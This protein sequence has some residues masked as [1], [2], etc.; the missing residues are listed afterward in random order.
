M[1]P[2]E[3]S[4]RPTKHAKREPGPHRALIRSQ[5][6]CLRCIGA[7]HV[8]PDAQLAR[9]AL[10]RCIEDDGG[11]RE[12]ERR[13]E[14]RQR[15]EERTADRL[16]VW[17]ARARDEERAGREEEVRAE[18]GDDGCRKPEGPVRRRRVYEGEEEV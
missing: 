16:F 11:D 6:C 15:L 18:D 1:N 2:K 14:L 10:E 12:P 4:Y 17:L 7:P 5:L 8:C 9:L 3:G 13:A